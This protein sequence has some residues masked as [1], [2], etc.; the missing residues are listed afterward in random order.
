VSKAGAAMVAALFAA[1]LAPEGIQV[2]D[3]RPGIIATDMSAPALADYR[4]RIAEEGILLEPRVGR[5]EDVAHAVHAVATGGLP[6]AVGLVLKI[7]GGVTMAR[8]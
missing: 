8:L 5:P 2:A 7:D 1:R 6:Y 4:R 3:I